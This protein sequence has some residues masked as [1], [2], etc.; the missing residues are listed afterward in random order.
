MWR[1]ISLALVVANVVFWL[2]GHEGLRAL[3]MG[4]DIVQEPERLKNQI[5][6]DSMRVSPKSA[7]NDKIPDPAVKVLSPVEPLPVPPAKGN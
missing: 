3:D 4:P 2:W 1:W 6:P 7:L 5:Q